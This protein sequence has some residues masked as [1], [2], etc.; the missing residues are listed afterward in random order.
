MTA[1][2][3]C[4]S[5]LRGISTRVATI[6]D[7]Y[8]AEQ[9]IWIPASAFEQFIHT[10]YWG[11]FADLDLH[12][13]DGLDAS[14]Y[15][16]L[17]DELRAYNVYLQRQRERVSR[18]HQAYRSWLGTREKELPAEYREQLRFW[19]QYY[20]SYDYYRITGLATQSGYQRFIADP[21]RSIDNFKRAFAELAAQRERERAWS[22]QAEADWRSNTT[23]MR[24]GGR[25]LIQ[26]E[27]ALRYLGLAPGATLDD[28][29]Q[30]YRTRAK[31]IH[32]DRQREDSTAQ[33]VALN[34]VYELLCRFYHTV[35]SEVSGTGR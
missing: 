26:I 7:R 5:T 17:I 25:T 10:L 15:R 2:R 21:Q 13:L 9:A 28:I 35:A 23:Y 18:F 19:H 16:D 12:L 33:M 8:P 27:Q 24:D 6:L 29:K 30:A 20:G 11:N 14:D 1:E 32:P 3:V 4:L 34:Q 31:A 22:E